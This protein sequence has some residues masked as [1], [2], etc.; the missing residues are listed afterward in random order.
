MVFGTRPAAWNGLH[1]DVCQLFQVE[2][3]ADGLAIVA[4][5]LGRVER[6]QGPTAFIDTHQRSRPNPPAGNQN[7]PGDNGNHRIDY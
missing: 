1:G 7:G 4:Q 2:N 3:R 5:R 6:G